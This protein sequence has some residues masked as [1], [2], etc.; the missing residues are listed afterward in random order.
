MTSELHLRLVTIHPFI[1]GNGRASRLLMNLYL[2]QNGFPI[3]IIKGDTESRLAYY[4]ALEDS[5][6]NGSDEFISF[7]LNHTEQSIDRLLS[8][9]K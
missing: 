9:I 3:V 2:L 4:D 7:V 6:V 5:Q 8:I 1:D